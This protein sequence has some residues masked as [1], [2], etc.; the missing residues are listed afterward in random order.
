MKNTTSPF[1]AAATATLLLAA[2][3]A[4]A[5]GQPLHAYYTKV[6]HSTTDYM[7]QF[8]DIVVVLEEDKQLEFTRRTGYLP[9]WRV[10]NDTW[11][12]DDFFPRRKDDFTFD[13]NYVR[14][15]ENTPEKVVVQ[16][17]YIPE[18]RTI[19]A[20]NR[21]LNPM[22]VDGITG[23]VHE[24]FTIYP[25]GR[26]KREI[27]EA[28]N[29][30]YSDWVDPRARTRQTLTLSNSGIEHS[31]VEW[32]RTG[33]LYPR[34]A[35]K[36]SPVKELEDGPEPI[37]AWTFDSGMNE[38]EDLVFEDVAES[39]TRIGGLMSVFKE[40]VSGTAL[41]F[42]GYY[43]GVSVPDNA[44]QFDDALSLEAW[45]ALDVYPYNVAPIVH[46]SE[47]FGQRGYYLGVDAYGH[48]VF[49]ANG[50]KVVSSEALPL[51]KWAHTAVTVG[52]GTIRL[53]IDGEEV[54]TGPYTGAIKMPDV[55][56]VIGLNTSKERCTDFVRTNAQNLLFIYGIQG[57]IDEV[58]IYDRA[59]SKSDLQKTYTTFLP[60]DRTSA[61][62]K[63]VLPG[64][65]GVPDSF[66]ATYKTLDFQ[67]TWDKLWR[68]SDY[69]DIVVKFENNPGSVVF[70]RGTNYA[71]NWV[72][73]NNRWMADQSSEIFTAH[74]CSEHMADKQVRHSYARI[75]E[76]TPARVVV[77]W[78][79]PCVDVSY[80][81]LDRRN[82]SD[83][84]HTF[85]PDGT[86]VRKV[87]WNKGYNTPGFQDIQFFTN[88]GETALDVMNLQALTIANAKGETRELL[89]KTPAS[90]PENTLPDAT[91]ELM[92]SKS[93][94]KVFAIFQGGFISPWGHNEQS[95][96][97]EDP[98]AGPW[99]H[100]PVN[101][102]PSDGRFAVTHD[103]VTHFAIAAN[104]STPEFGSMVLYGLAEESIK[105][106]VPLARSWQTPPAITD[107]RGIINAQFDKAQNAF[108]LTRAA[109]TMALTIE[110][111]S[112]SPVV[113][114]CLVINNWDSNQTATLKINGAP[115]DNLHQGITYDTNGIRKK[116]IWLEHQT[117]QPIKIEIKRG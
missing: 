65:V 86:G 116:I 91:I 84:Y 4:H 24:F 19:E 38:H 81:C 34:A 69:A 22:I 75:I 36:G 114:P 11:T 95:K 102:V 77:H 43:T 100:W 72:T 83:E 92:N 6:A 68:V 89:W 63:G 15:I 5:A 2:P 18:P 17:R 49:Q 104:D 94:Q 58:K 44:P 62:T 9:L 74:G 87:V 71:A 20:A 23:A 1:I 66:G 96:Y 16:W 111:S 106:L 53:Y 46:Q 88:P 13:Y 115:A 101:L 7:G 40:G 73:D 41:A 105:T 82:W 47:A 56:V 8:P 37:R 42:D 78:R 107:T 108:T 97:T 103:R 61:F 110:A 50:K 59:L 33:A 90:P 10:G 27:R 79:Y 117:N 85:Y 98:F 112:A 57:L 109:N 35:T 64:E 54:A 14:L 3:I 60:K 39:E 45:V 67:E 48:L 52:G 31:S 26:V 29:T 55:P 28:K 80:L 70:W 12:A 21:E 93:N 76:N 25:D 51:Y 113:N 99:N 30:R 32:G